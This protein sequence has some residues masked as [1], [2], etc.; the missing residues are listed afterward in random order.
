MIERQGG[1]Q[2]HE[3]GTNI[4]HSLLHDTRGCVV[5]VEALIQS[6]KQWMKHLSVFE[7]WQCPGLSSLARKS[8]V[9]HFP[10]ACK[11]ETQAHTILIWH[12]ATYYC[13]ISP[14]KLELSGSR[15]QVDV[16]IHHSVTTKPSR[17]CGYRP[18]AHWNCSHLTR[19]AVPSTLT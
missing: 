2:A 5:I 19:R 7:C 18:L 13:E 3:N 8:L 16:L 6:R 15:E 4:M 17:Y 11:Q 9:E 10:W 1:H 12:I 14:P